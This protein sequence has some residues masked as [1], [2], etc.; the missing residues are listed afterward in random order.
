[1]GERNGFMSLIPLPP[2]PVHDVLQPSR[3][4]GTTTPSRRRVL[5][6]FIHGTGQ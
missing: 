3:Y 6:A 1:V 5:H 4:N 2:A